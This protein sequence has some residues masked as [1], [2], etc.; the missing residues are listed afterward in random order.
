M[1]ITERINSFTDKYQKTIQ[2]GNR[3]WRYYR[4]GEGQPILWLTGGLRRAALGFEFMEKLGAR[5]TV[6]AP[7]YPPVETIDEFIAAFDSILQAEGV[8][9]FVLG[10]QSYGGLLAQAYLAR[11]S[12]AV[13]KLILSS[14]GPADYGKAWLPVEYIFIGLARMLPEKR[15]KNLLSRGLLKFISLPASEREEW[16]AA[17]NSVMQDDLSRQD[18]ISHFAVAADLIRKKIVTPG[19][20][21]NWTGRIIVLSAKNDPTQSPKDIPLYQKLFGRGVEV[22]DLGDMGH[23]AAMFDVDRYVQL[24]DQALG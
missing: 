9:T 5:H 12:E 14:T 19:V 24:I 22:I 10:G 15:V 8:N 7:D 2:V 11:R 3:T 20:Y 23:A 13:E 1:T 21:K 17:I 4:L 18:V 16:E 6:I